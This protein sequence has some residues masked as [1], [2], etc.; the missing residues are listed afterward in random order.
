MPFFAVFVL[1]FGSCDPV[2]RE[3]Y[4]LELP[5][6]PPE[7]TAMLGP[8]MWRIEWIDRDG[9]VR[10]TETGETAVSGV[11][12][13]QEWTT[14]IIAYP[15]WPHRGIGPRVM[16]PGGALFPFDARGG[17]ITLSWKAGVDAGF[18]LALAGVDTAGDTRNPRYFNWP[19]FRTLWDDPR[20]AGEIRADPWLADWPSISR[21]T[22]QSGFDWR[23]IIP[24]EREK[25]PVTVPQSGPWVGTSPFAEPLILEAGKTA[26][27]DVT[28]EVDT[29]ISAGGILRCTRGAWIW[30]PFE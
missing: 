10:V 14:P 28:G 7:W 2:L 27:L 25:L 29:Y 9:V 18:Y 12:L 20:V 30:I 11:E 13:F 8:P 16:C 24:R 21:H 23:R 17:R 4:R 19:R 3:A 5:P 15:Y 26:S 6:P 1:S 22:V